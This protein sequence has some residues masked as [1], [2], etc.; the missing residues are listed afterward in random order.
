MDEIYQ[1]KSLDAEIL[2]RWSKLLKYDFFRL[3][4]QHLILYA[5]ASEMYHKQN[6]KSEL[7]K[8]RKNIYT[9]EVIEFI[10]ELIENNE[11][12]KQQIITEYRIPKTTLYK[13]I[14]KYKNNETKK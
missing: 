2:L 7:P 14:A 1:S 6:E 13:W 8:F 11:K 9:K 4:S 3:Y 10:L 5:P 12:T